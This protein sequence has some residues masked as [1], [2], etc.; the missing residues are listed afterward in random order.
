[1]REARNTKEIIKKTHNFN[2][3]LCHFDLK[4]TKP[5]K[6]ETKAINAKSEIKTHRARNECNKRRKNEKPLK[7][8]LRMDCEKKVEEKETKTRTKR[9]KGRR[10]ILEF[11]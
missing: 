10:L 2:P 6:I 11:L 9:R 4:L 3:K 1:M 5:S 7:R 8:S